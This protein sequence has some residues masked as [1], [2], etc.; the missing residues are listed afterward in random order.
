MR[1]QHNLKRLSDLC[2]TFLLDVLGGAGAVWGAAEA[3]KVRGGPNNDDWRIIC[4]F[5]G[6][7]CFIRWFV[8]GFFDVRYLHGDVLATFLLQVCGAAGAIWGA[9]EMLGLRINYPEDCHEE[10]QSLGGPFVGPGNAWA[11]GYDTCQNT[12]QF[13]TYVCGVV[14][15]IFF[16]RWNGDFPKWLKSGNQ[17]RS[18]FHFFHLHVCTFVLEVMGGAGAVWGASEI[19]G[20]SGSSLRL[21]WGDKNYGQ[22]SFDFWRWVCLVTFCLC[23]LRWAMTWQAR[24]SARDLDK[25]EDPAMELAREIESKTAL[26]RSASGMVLTAPRARMKRQGAMFFDDVMMRQIEIEHIKKGH[27]SAMGGIVPEAKA[28]QDGNEDWKEFEI[29]ITDT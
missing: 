22:E 7:A 5:V 23:F 21:G 25:K 3:F 28:K 9:A 8:A 2:T 29:S 6:A 12:Y 27:V 19:I 1:A 15:V 11:P 24:E 4:G 18:I 20:P 16:V 26:R 17:R 14:F 13:W 10:Q